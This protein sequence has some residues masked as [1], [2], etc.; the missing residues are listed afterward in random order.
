MPVALAARRSVLR[1]GV[2]TNDT[3]FSSFSLSARAGRF[4][5]QVGLN[6]RFATPKNNSSIS[7]SE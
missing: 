2:N 3:S 7:D 6:Q 5:P 1:S 4:S